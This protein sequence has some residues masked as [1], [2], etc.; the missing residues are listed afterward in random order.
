M[1]VTVLN[2]LYTA[3]PLVAAI[4]V[5]SFIV[6][7]YDKTAAKRKWRRIPEAS[8]LLISLLGGSAAMLLTMLFIRHKTRHLKFMVGIPLI[9]M[10]QIC[11]IGALIYFFNITY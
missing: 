9:I 3:A 10:L 6:T 4:S 8:L 11:I 5:F 7:V 2:V 1:C